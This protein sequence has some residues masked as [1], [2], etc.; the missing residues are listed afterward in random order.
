MNLEFQ[1]EA[2][3]LPFLYNR[4]STLYKTIL[5]F[6]M[7]VGYV[8]DT[9]VLQINPKWTTKARKDMYLGEATEALLVNLNLSET[10]LNQFC[11][12]CL[13]Y[14]VELAVQI[15][16]RFSDLPKYENSNLLYPDIVL[17][18]N[19][20]VIPLL[21]QFTNLT[22]KNSQCISNEY[23]VIKLIRRDKAK[24][25]SIRFLVILV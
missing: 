25:E 3:Q 16:K 11:N 22:N 6:F 17:N 1:S 13:N 10:N 8:N 23:R 7:D 20:K 9:P 5:I 21:L 19:K 4:I 2:T 14:Y 12:N 24:T 15:Q 18:S